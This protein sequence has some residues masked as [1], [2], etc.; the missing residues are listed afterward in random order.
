MR[1]YI[2]A[3]RLHETEKR[4]EKPLKESDHKEEY[5]EA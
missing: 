2:I 3:A 4:G 5:V 1:C